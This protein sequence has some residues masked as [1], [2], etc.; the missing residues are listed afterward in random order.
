MPRQLDR[1]DFDRADAPWLVAVFSSATCDSCATVLRKSAVLASAD[2]VVQDVE[3][4]ARGD[5]HQRYGIEAVPTIVVAD[6]E[7]V[8]RASFVGA[9]V[10]H[11]PVGG[12]GRGPGAGIEPRTRAGPS[13]LT[14][15]PGPW[16]PGAT[17]E[18]WSRR[19]GTTSGRHG[20]RAG[21]EELFRARELT[22]NL[23]RRDLK[24][25]HRGTFLGMLW[26]LT[27][28]AAL[29]RPLLLHLH[30]HLPGRRR[31]RT[32]PAPTARSSRSPSTS[33][34]GWSSGTSSATSV[35][36]VDRQRHRAPAT[37]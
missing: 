26:S 5:L 8:V 37:C 4:G 12:G 32:P 1:A 10:G 20:L 14:T 25:R 36:D 7:G 11:R 21:V 15:R 19:R 18:G 28:P 31:A 6:A 24:V 22:A 27:T 13:T 30:V 29:R 35:G 34:A 9:A 3:V 16:R 2:V 33:S 17:P 23:V